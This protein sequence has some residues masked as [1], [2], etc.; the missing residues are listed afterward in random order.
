MY[1]FTT[2]RWQKKTALLHAK[3]SACVWELA[4]VLLCGLVVSLFNSFI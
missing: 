2:D 4:N 3:V 1:N